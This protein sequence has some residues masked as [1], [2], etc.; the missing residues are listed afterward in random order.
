MENNSGDKGSSIKKN[1]TND[2]KISPPITNRES[3]H[4]LERIK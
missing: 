2:V 3:I 1:K 4:S